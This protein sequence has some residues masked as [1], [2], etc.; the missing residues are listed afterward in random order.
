MTSAVEAATA[1]APLV[2]SRAEEA[3]ALRRLPDDVVIAL[4][5]A[6][7][8]RMCVPTKYGGPE[9]D[10]LTMMTAIE[11]VAAADG[12]AGWCTM[13]AS[14]TSSMSLFLH[15]DWARQIYGDPKAITGGA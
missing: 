9:V 11:V 2:R 10:P 14:T 6:G 4:R 15:P 7:L 3:E 1:V 5:D 8:L 12:A 13:I